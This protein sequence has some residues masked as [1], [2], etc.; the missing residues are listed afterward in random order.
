M[1]FLSEDIERWES[2][3]RLKGS[4]QP[5]A[6]PAR[7]PNTFLVLG[8]EADGKILSS[9]IAFDG[10]TCWT[11]HKDAK[12]GD[13]V[14]F[15]ITA[16]TSA[17]VAIGKVNC[18]PEYQPDP[19]EAW[20][21]HWLG[22]VSELKRTKETPMRELRRLFPDWRQLVYLRRNARVPADI[23]APLLELINI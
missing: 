6:I 14:L 8:S 3:Q 4:V 11:L 23:V 21:K 7:A 1:G 15:Y 16:P 5:I 17:I 2:L 9:D 22:E 19:D 12:I 10:F 18:D 13:R 20:Y